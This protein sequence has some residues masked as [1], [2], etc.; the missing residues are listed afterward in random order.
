MLEHYPQVVQVSASAITSLFDTFN[1]SGSGLMNFDELVK[2]LSTLLRGTAKQ[3]A[4]MLFSIFDVL[5]LGECRVTAAAP[6]PVACLPGAT[7]HVS[8]PH[9]AG[10][11]SETDMVEKLRCAVATV[12]PSRNGT[13]PRSLVAAASGRFL[14]LVDVGGDDDGDDDGDGDG[15]L[16]VDA[17]PSGEGKGDEESEGGGEGE[18]KGEGEGDAEADEQTAAEA[19]AAT[20]DTAFARDVRGIAC[21]AVGVWC[22]GPQ[23][24]ACVFTLCV[25]ARDG[26][27]CLSAAVRAA[28]H[29]ADNVSRRDRRDGSHTLPRLHV[30]ATSPPTPVR[31]LAVLRTPPLRAPPPSAVLHA[32][33]AT[34][35]CPSLHMRSRG[36][37]RRR[38][39]RRL[40]AGSTAS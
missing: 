21:R 17:A 25:C 2:G 5:G 36:L 13:Q 38:P 18:G 11:L 40:P 7:P 37:T 35:A 16:Q 10:A 33:P 23:L 9:A 20:V 14:H 22:G 31:L 29:R 15:T 3:K 27:G 8:H 28:A 1:T 30:C 34:P 19:L 6:P 39:C 24:N 26:R 4:A 12:C 32:L